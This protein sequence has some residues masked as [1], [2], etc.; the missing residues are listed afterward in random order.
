M[1]ELD[2]ALH[3]LHPPDED[4][5]VGEITVFV[6]GADEAPARPR[7]TNP[8]YDG[9]RPTPPYTIVCEAFPREPTW[10]PALPPATHAPRGRANRDLPPPL[11]RTRG[12]HHRGV[13]LW[14]ERPGTSLL[15]LVVAT[16]RD[17]ERV[18]GITPTQLYGA[19]PVPRPPLPVPLARDGVHTFLRT[20]GVTAVTGVHL[21]RLPPAPPDDPRG[22][23][24][25][26][27]A[28]NWELW[29]DAWAAWLPRLPS[30]CRWTA[31]G[32]RPYGADATAGPPLPPPRR[33]LHS[34]AHGTTL[35]HRKVVGRAH[36]PA[37][38]PTRITVM[39]DSDGSPQ[40][41][42]CHHRRSRS[43][44]PVSPDWAGETPAE[45]EER[46]LAEAVVLV[47]PPAGQPRAASADTG[48]STQEPEPAE[49][50][51]PA[52]QVASPAAPPR[53]G[54]QDAR[55]A[56]AAAQASHAAAMTAAAGRPPTR[57]V[58]PVQERGASPRAAAAAEGSEEGARGVATAAPA[59]RATASAGH[60]AAPSTPRKQGTDP[61]RAT[62]ASPAAAAAAAVGREGAKY[63]AQAKPNHTHTSPSKP[64]PRKP[65]PPW[66]TRHIRPP[67]PERS[68]PGVTLPQLQRQQDA[69][70]VIQ[71][72]GDGT[73]AELRASHGS[74]E[75]ER[76][77]DR[78]SA[79]GH[80]Q[81]A[82]QGTRGKEQGRKHGRG[83]EASSSGGGR[84]A[85]TGRRDIRQ[86]AGKGPGHGKGAQGRGEPRP[87]A[88]SGARD[89]GRA[90]AQPRAGA[91]ARDGHGRRQ[92]GPGRG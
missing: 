59:R 48:P 44:S 13:V 25:L 82:G 70:R 71:E 62:G 18:L 76:E 27:P 46:R 38:M 31:T 87:G 61:A 85:G 5:E 20:Q 73:Q 15:L 33:A 37:R 54:A 26:G 92:C 74:A 41:D 30:E 21:V 24:A 9:T 77:G 56:D 6:E 7:P 88:W 68:P 52:A 69:R 55:G 23:R 63:R 90:R 86:G 36:L 28:P 8:V 11:S 51:A 66:R 16:R 3:L 29:R 64:F 67:A 43:C 57:G 39:S 81:G 17:P 22:P 1:S 49:V 58:A 91:R 32:P 72:G 14:Q 47:G 79:Q 80:A 34:T 78:E 53:E 10:C 60:S 42:D 89:G 12:A 84:S 35:M 19:A 75:R 83:T 45:R 2:A 4:L 40:Q 65:F 50:T